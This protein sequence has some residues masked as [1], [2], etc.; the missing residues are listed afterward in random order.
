[1]SLTRNLDISGSRDEGS[2]CE[3]HSEVLEVKDRAEVKS[4]QK[5]EVANDLESCSGSGSLK[6]FGDLPP[7][8]LSYIQQLQSELTSVTEVTLRF[9][10]QYF[11]F[12]DCG[13]AAFIRVL[14]RQAAG[15]LV[16]ILSLCIGDLSGKKRGPQL[17]GHFIL[18]DCK[19]FASYVCLVG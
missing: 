4:D 15:A 1:M 18:S 8:A 16:W 11:Q 12:N 13:M 14:C 5:I 6:E 17:N 9:L 3:T 10:V 19:M 2:D 7:H